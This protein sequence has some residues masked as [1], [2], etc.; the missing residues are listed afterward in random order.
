MVGQSFAVE[1][2]AFS[3]ENPDWPFTAALTR[4]VEEALLTARNTKTH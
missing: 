1:N 2:R 3:R 4:R